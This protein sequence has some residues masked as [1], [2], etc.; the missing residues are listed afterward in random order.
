[1]ILYANFY[2]PFI[3]RELDK[4]SWNDLPLFDDY[5]KIYHF[6]KSLYR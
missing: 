1:M 5:F 4:V 6:V 3:L 2:P